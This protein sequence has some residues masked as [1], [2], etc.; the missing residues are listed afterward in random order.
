MVTGDC[1]LQRKLWKMQD[2]IV[3]VKIG[4]E[5]RKRGNKLESHTS[6][7]S[8]NE[9]QR[10]QEHLKSQVKTSFIILMNTIQI[11]PTFSNTKNEIMLSHMLRRMSQLR[12]SIVKLD[13]EL[14][15]FKV[16]MNHVERKCLRLINSLRSVAPQILPNC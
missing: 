8:A 9:H 12:P 13:N 1:N 16:D 7:N 11:L 4:P 5:K 2:S 14:R 3:S 10:G 15:Q 6:R